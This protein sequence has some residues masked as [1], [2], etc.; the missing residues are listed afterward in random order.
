MIPPRGTAERAELDR[1]ARAVAKPGA[2]LTPAQR[3]RVRELIEDE[4]Q[5]RAEAIAWVQAFE[6]DEQT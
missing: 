5:T 1:Q 4:G 2:R 6:P 3:R